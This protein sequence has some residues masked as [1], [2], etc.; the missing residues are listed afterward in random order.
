[1]VALPV[2]LDPLEATDGPK[3][4]E[5]LT[6]SVH[7]AAPARSRRTKK[8]FGERKEKPDVTRQCQSETTSAV[9]NYSNL[10]QKMLCSEAKR[11]RNHGR[12]K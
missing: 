1:M 5:S 10:K 4:K 6:P 8:A 3:A 9:T 2:A 11:Q 12:R 7:L